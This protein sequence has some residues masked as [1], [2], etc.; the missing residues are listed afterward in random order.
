M[1]RNLNKYC[2]ICKSLPVV[3]K[4][5]QEGVIEF[6]VDINGI[7]SEK[8][9]IQDTDPTGVVYAVCCNCEKEWELKGI[10]QASQY[11]SL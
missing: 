8:G 5:K 2:P 3:L 10:T 11:S 1:N 4:E 6:D 9:E 7:V